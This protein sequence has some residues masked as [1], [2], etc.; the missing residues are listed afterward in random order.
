MAARLRTELP[1]LRVEISSDLAPFYRQVVTL[2]RN[3]FMV[4]G[5][6]IVAV[7]GLSV[8]NTMLM[9][10]SERIREMGTLLAL[11]I[12]RGTIRGTF[13]FEGAIIGTLGALAGIA[14]ALT[15]AI[16]V[17]FANIQMPPPGANDAVS[18]SGVRGRLCVW[19][20][21]APDVRGGHF[22][23]LDAH[24]AVDAPASRRG[25]APHLRQILCGGFTHAHRQESPVQTNHYPHV[26][27]ASRPQCA[28]LCFFVFHA[29]PWRLSRSR[30]R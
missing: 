7:V 23:S 29:I 28:S 6:I 16:A 19:G 10:I 17:N 4:L 8:T 30:F 22:C 27:F 11:G 18:P 2:Y 15:I 26:P 14:L 9:A 12:G 21:T 13:A 25:A 3:I 24:S 1:G 20:G 5:V